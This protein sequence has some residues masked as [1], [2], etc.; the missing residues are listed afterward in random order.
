M[1]TIKKQNRFAGI[2]PVLL[3]LWPDNCDQTVLVLVLFTFIN[4]MQ[5]KSFKHK[6]NLDIL[7]CQ[8]KA[9]HGI[10]ATVILIKASYSVFVVFA[11]NKSIPNN[12]E[13]FGGVWSSFC[14]FLQ[15]CLSAGRKL[16]IMN[17]ARGLSS[18]CWEAEQAYLPQALHS[19]CSLLAHK[20]PSHPW[21]PSTKYK[22]KR[23]TII[24]KK[25]KQTLRAGRLF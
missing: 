23:W 6:R 5:S 8:P 22:G 25:E 4:S 19:S 17:T 12:Q 10:L 14:N 1:S 18:Y 9:F 13:W 11:E 2:K 20:Q 16:Q 7:N 24:P 15:G 3:L 21:H